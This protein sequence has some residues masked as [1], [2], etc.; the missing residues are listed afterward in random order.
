[1]RRSQLYTRHT[2]QF[3]SRVFQSAERAETLVTGPRAT[4]TLSVS[5]D[6]ATRTDKLCRELLFAKHDT[7]LSAAQ[8][9]TIPKIYFSEKVQW[10]E[11]H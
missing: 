11:S 7:C 10:G 3:L 1:M 2:V 4:V 8:N 6:S 9:D 5:S